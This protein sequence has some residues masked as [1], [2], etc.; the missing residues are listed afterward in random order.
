M[1]TELLPK[2]MSSDASPTAAQSGIA[3]A[4]PFCCALAA[5]DAEQDSRLIGKSK[6]HRRVIEQLDRLAPVDVE[7][8]ITGPTGVGKELYAGYVHRHS[9][10]ASRAFVAV[11]CGAMPPELIENE[12]FGHATGAY[13]S[14]QGQSRGLAAEAQGGT[15]F[16][17][18]VDSLPIGSQAKLLRFIQEKEYRRLGETRLQKADVRIVVATNTNLAAAVGAKTF[19]QDLFFRLRAAPVEVPSL[20]QRREDIPLL[21][22][23]F[24]ARYSQDYRLPRV[25][26]GERAAKRLITY[27]WPGNI[28]ELENCVRYLTCLR[29]QRPV[30]LDD[31]PLLDDGAEKNKFPQIEQLLCAASLKE[32]KRELV[33]WFE[34]AYL[35]NALRQSN[36]NIAAAA[37]ASG[38]DRRVFFELMRKRGLCGG[39]PSPEGEP[40]DCAED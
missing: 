25:E 36:G 30:D 24:V 5:S 31:L 37:R 14:A 3:R 22:A 11:N 33:S 2:R 18:E 15:L 28:R 40:G 9:R 38:T 6:A 12:L 13:T 27:A 8:L 21:L 39:A 35:E 4:P 16:L 26:F 34:R 10:R 32:A 20:A 29:L 19:R 7:V 1:R 23:A 17:D